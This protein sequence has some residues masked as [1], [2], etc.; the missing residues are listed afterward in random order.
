MQMCTSV[1]HTPA[2]GTY[3][4]RTGAQV[5]REGLPRPHCLPAQRRASPGN[6]TF[7]LCP[8]QAPLICSVWRG[9]R[10]AGAQGTLAT[11]HLSAALCCAHSA[12]LGLQV[13]SRPESAS[14]SGDRMRVWG[15]QRACLPCGAVAHTTRKSESSQPSPGAL[16][17]GSQVPHHQGRARARQG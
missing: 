3:T 5:H 17:Q 16:R 11:G 10:Q 13:M 1:A 9:C 15:E 14:L 2:T 8:D 6:L 7:S 4:S 12:C